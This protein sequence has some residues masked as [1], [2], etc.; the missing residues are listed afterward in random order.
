MY[1]W[2]HSYE[3]GYPDDWSL[4]TEFADMMAGKEDIW[5]ATNGEIYDYI[6][7]VRRLEYSADMSL[8]RNPSAIPVWYKCGKDGNDKIEPGKTIE[9]Q[10]S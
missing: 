10:R 7:A 4:I 6:T 9:I 3:F 1:V 8:V 5:Y 2:G